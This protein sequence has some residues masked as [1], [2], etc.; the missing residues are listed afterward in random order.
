MAHILHLVVKDALC[1]EDRVANSHSASR[2]VIASE[3]RIAGHFKT[4]VK[5]NNL[6]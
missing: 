3:K 5:G 2:E 4:I 1:L 6:L